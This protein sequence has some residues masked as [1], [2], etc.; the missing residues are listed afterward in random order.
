[1]SF[2]WISP[3]RTD[4]S[5]PVVRSPARS[6]IRANSLNKI[7]FAIPHAAAALFA[8]YDLIS[9]VYTFCATW[10]LTTCFLTLSF[11]LSACHLTQVRPRFGLVYL[12]VYCSSECNFLLLFNGLIIWKI[13]GLK[14]IRIDDVD[15]FIFGFFIK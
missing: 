1:M 6:R 14:K 12:N 4:P 15:L 13:H 8:V 11:K 5:R 9:H 3:H 10:N 2:N 7:L